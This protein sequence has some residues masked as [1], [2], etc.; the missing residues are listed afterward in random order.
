MFRQPHL[1]ATIWQKMPVFSC[2]PADS[3]VLTIIMFVLDLAGDRFLE[4]LRI[5]TD[6]S[7]KTYEQ[8]CNN[9]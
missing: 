9:S 8:W 6:T 2:S 5:T 1:T 4:R 7:R 3:W